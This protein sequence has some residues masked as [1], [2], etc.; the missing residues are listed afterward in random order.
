MNEELNCQIIKM[1]AMF[2]SL[3]AHS[4]ESLTEAL[5]SLHNTPEFKKYLKQQHE[6]DNTRRGLY[7]R[8]H[9]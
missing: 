4:I 7:R 3:F 6:L 1:S 8:K 5:Q 2:T 9:K